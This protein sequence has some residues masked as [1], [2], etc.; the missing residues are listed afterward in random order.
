MRI[1]VQDMRRE[2]DYLASGRPG[3]EPQRTSGFA[4][5]A[6]ADRKAVLNSLP[7][8]ERRLED[9]LDRRRKSV[10]ALLAIDDGLIG[11]PVELDGAALALE[12]VMTVPRIVRS[13][14]D[15]ERAAGRLDLGGEIFQISAV[16]QD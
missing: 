1:V 11:H 2:W 15:E 6:K 10:T 13:L 16:A 8:G 14:E 12:R 3:P 9:A 5:R 4:G 7:P